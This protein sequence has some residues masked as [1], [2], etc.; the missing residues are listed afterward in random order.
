MWLAQRVSAVDLDF[1]ADRRFNW[2]GSF[3]IITGAVVL[4]FMVWTYQDLS[5]KLNSQQIKILKLKEQG[6][7]LLAPTV[8]QPRDI[9]QSNRETKH[10]NAVIL[11]L[12]L[13]WKEFFEALEA[14]QTSEVAVLTIEP[15]AQKGVVRISAEAKK[16]DSMLA[17]VA[18][19]QKITMFHDVLVMSHQIQDQDPQKPIRFVIQA[20]WETHL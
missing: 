20:S 12:S 8:A 5:Y 17:Y 13:P 14:S 11:A 9:E 4:I 7:S 2:A 10:A 19:L 3:A 1:L 15:N 18:S 16:M 6:K